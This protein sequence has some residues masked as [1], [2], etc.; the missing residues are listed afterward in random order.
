MTAHFHIRDLPIH[1]DDPDEILEAAPL[2]A[3]IALLRSQWRGA[4]V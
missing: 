1:S 3:E 4:G 2:D